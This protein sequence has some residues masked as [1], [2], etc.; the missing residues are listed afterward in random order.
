MISA[1]STFKNAQ[2]LLIL[3]SALPF[4]KINTFLLRI[5]FHRHNSSYH[6]IIFRNLCNIV[7]QKKN[8]KEYFSYN[9]LSRVRILSKDCIVMIYFLYFHE[10]KWILLTE[11]WSFWKEYLTLFVMQRLCQIA[12]KIIQ[13]KFQQF[14]ASKIVRIINIPNLKMN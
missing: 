2:Q 11:N 10:K 7:S 8:R 13:E 14:N 5:K 4:L 12:I 1:S 3:F 9:L 6:I